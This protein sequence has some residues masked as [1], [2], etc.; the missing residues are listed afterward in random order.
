VRDRTA[1]LVGGNSHTVGFGE[2]CNLP[3]LGDAPGMDY[4]RLNDGGSLGVE[5]LPELGAGEQSLAGGDGNRA[6]GGYFA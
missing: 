6:P 4:V 2:A 5:Q 3:N 1:A